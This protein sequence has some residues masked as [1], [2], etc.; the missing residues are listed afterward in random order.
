MQK[1]NDEI[2][3]ISIITE[4]DITGIVE[5]YRQGNWWKEKWN[6]GDIGPLIKGS[7]L[8][9]IAT[10][11]EKRAV[12]MGRVLSDG[13]S[14]GYIQDLVVHNDYRGT[15]L[16]RRI[17]KTLVMESRNRGLMWIGLIAEPGTSEFYKTEGFSVMANHIPMVLRFDDD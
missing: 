13:C 9:A 11:N 4:W 6:P 17:L 12:G 10:D 16:G 1:Q 5:L 3:N 2:I 15:G 7:F 14:D 8:F